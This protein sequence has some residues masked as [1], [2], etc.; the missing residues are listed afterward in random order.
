MA[1]SLPDDIPDMAV[2]EV[3]P[4]PKYWKPSITLDDAIARLDPGLIR[5]LQKELGANFREV[6]P[7]VRPREHKKAIPTETVEVDSDPADVE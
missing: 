6:R 5:T 7:F 1:E 4:D 2:A 3:Q